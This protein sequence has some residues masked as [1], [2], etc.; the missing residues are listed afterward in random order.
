MKN[1]FFFNRKIELNYCD[2]RGRVLGNLVLENFEF[3]VFYSVFVLCRIGVG[4][5][6]GCF[7]E[8]ERDLIFSY[9]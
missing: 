1:L 9:N 8:Q 6:Q 5:C 7:I 3:Q 4:V 2:R